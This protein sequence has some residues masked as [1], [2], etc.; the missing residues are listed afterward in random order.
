MYPDKFVSK[1]EEIPLEEHFAIFEAASYYTEGYDKGDSGTNT[2]FVQYRAYLTKETLLEG[3]R[4]SE[5]SGYGK[6]SYKVCKIIPMRIEIS[7][8]VAVR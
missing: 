6:K 7:I 1:P 3:I 4:Q 5:S 2:P 8:D